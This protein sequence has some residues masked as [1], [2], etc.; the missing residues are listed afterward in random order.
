MI[1][2]LL[3]AFCGLMAFIMA[4]ILQFSIPSWRFF[5]GLNRMKAEDLA[6]IEVPRL[7]RRLSVLMYILSAFFF[8][9]SILFYIKNISYML[10]IPLLQ[11]AVLLV[12]NGFWFCYRRFDHNRYPSR[13]LRA[14]FIFWVCANL[15]FLLP[16]VFYIL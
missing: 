1:V 11:G 7:R 4:I 2:L 3:C 5:A 8:T 15:F 13:V 14:A 9:G 12:F 6:N 16:L 10:L